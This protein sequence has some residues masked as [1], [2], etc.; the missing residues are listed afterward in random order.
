MSLK[1]FLWFLCLAFAVF[2]IISAPTDAARLVKSTGESAGDWLSTAAQ[3]L[4][5]FLRSLA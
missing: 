4:S 5:K 2:F 3:A 1:R